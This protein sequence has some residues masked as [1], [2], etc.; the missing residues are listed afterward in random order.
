MGRCAGPQ[1]ARVTHDATQLPANWLGFDAA[2]GFWVAGIVRRSNAGPVAAGELV[3]N[4][5]MQRPACMG[6]GVQQTALLEASY[7]Q[8]V[9]EH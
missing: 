9:L 5:C 7:R 3:V 1:G 4:A 2:G 6:Y 8:V